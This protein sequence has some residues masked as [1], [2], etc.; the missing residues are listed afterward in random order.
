VTEQV[1]DAHCHLVNVVELRYPWIEQT[2]PVLVNLLENYYDIAHDYGVADYRRDVGDRVGAAVACEF[3]AADGLAEAEWIQRCH[4]ATGTPDA[5]I[6]ALDLTAADVAERLARY[7][8]LPVV[9]AVRQPLYWAA[10][11]LRRLGA[12]PD[13]LTDPQWRRGFEQ[14]AASGLIWDL[15][16]YDEQIPAAMDLVRASPDTRIVLEGTGWPIDLSASGH[17]RWENRLRA[18]AELPNVTLKLQGLALLFGP[19]AEAV[20]PWLRTA[21]DVFGPDRC[22]FGTHFPVD[23]LLWTVD[24]LLAAVR[25]ALGDRDL[26]EFLGGC[27]RRQY[28]QP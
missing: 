9:R 17:R 28:L 19:S 21:V 8:D 20:A 6:A 10:D 26:T 14:V 22:M 18:I 24:D 16:V 4:D 1:V 7:R 11:P 23:T 2:N 5:F 13:Y 25:S 15:L 27:A 3:G 12:R